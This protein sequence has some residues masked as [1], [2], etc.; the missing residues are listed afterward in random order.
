MQYSTPPILSAKRSRIAAAI[1]VVAVL[2][3][4]WA[5]IPLL[6]PP[7]LDVAARAKAAREMLASVR[8]TRTVQPTPV[9]SQLPLPA[10]KSPARRKTLFIAAM[11]EPIVREN[12][13]IAKQRD[14]AIRAPEGSPEYAAL[15]RAY[16]LHPNVPRSALLRRIDIVPA[17]LALAQGAIESAWGTSRF[18]REGNA[19]FGE[20]TYN[21]ET[22][23]LSPKSAETSQTPFKVKSFTHGHLSVRSFMKTLNTNPAYRAL[24]QQRAALRAENMLP[25]GLALAPFLHGY[26]EIGAPYTKRVIATIHAGKLGTYDGLKLADQSNP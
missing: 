19:F 6:F 14:R 17:S 5:I 16:G 12:D 1:A 21:E 23:G 4:A 9:L 18:A 3:L 13:R 15:A 2:G 22:P 8:E 11:L 20:R 7:A 25:T 24:R 26:S 10:V